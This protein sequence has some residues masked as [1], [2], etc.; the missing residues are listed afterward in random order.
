MRTAFPPPNG[1]PASADL[2]VIASD[3]LP[4]SLT[5]ASKVGYSRNRHPP[6]AGPRTVEWIA[7]TAANPEARC[8]TETISSWSCGKG[9]TC[10]A[11][12]TVIAS[13][14]S[15]KRRDKE[16]ATGESA[17]HRGFLACA[18]DLGDGQP[19][20]CLSTPEGGSCSR[21]R[22][23]SFGTSGLRLS[24]NSA[25]QCVRHGCGSSSRPQSRLPHFC[26][27]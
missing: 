23:E 6:S 15:L 24:S 8:Q 9:G 10:G 19:V 18:E 20:S 12:G 22:T 21:R 27:G 1:R 26:S 13:T 2:K 17:R 5:A 25:P 3:N 4:A 7:I 16:H 11:D 14:S